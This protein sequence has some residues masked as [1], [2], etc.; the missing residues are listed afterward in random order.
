MIA[1][2]RFAGRRECNLD[3][4][5]EQLKSVPDTIVEGMYLRFTEAARG[6]SE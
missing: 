4:L 3:T 1:F 2:R 5:K 6:S